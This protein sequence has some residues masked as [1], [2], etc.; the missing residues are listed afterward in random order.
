MM[1]G[2]SDRLVAAV[3]RLRLRQKIAGATELH[4]HRISNPWHA[5]SIVTGSVVKGDYTCPAAMALREKRFLSGEAPQLPL[6]DCA[7]PGRCAC[8]Y[9]HHADRRTNKRRARDNGLPARDFPGVER[10]G[11]TRGRRAVDI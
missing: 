8:H 10:R 2:W 4:N 3:Y 11:I 6:A 9:Q 7:K 1:T 5:I